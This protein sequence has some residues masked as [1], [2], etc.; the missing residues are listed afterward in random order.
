MIAF[1]SLFVRFVIH[2][3]VFVLFCFVFL[4][5]ANQVEETLHTHLPQTPETNFRVSFQ[6][7]CRLL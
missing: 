1:R 3:H 6:C 5:I 2:I 4:S 7:V